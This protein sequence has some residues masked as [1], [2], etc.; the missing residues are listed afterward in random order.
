MYS[1]ILELGRP[2]M[3]KGV[4]VKKENRITNSEDPDEPSH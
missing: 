1:S 4:S 2:L 3:Q